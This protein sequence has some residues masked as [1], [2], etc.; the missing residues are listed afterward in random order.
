MDKKV[1]VDLYQRLM[2]VVN[3]S[4]FSIDEQLEYFAQLI[5][6]SLDLKEIDGIVKALQLSE[7]VDI[8]RL[9]SRQKSIYFYYIA[10][11]WG[12]KRILKH[13]KSIDG[14]RWEWKQ[15]ELENELFYLRAS[16]NQD[17]FQNLHSVTKCHILTN[18]GNLFD[19]VG[20]FIEA[21]EYWDR[22]LELEPEFGLALG[23][24]GLGLERYA[25]SLYDTGHQGL[26]LKESHKYLTS[27]IRQLT[28]NVAYQN[29]ISIFEHS[30]TRTEKFIGGDADHTCLTKE[31]TL[32]KTN[33]EKQY[34]RWCLDNRLFL[35]PLND[36]GSYSIAAQDI[37]T[38]PNMVTGI[39][40]G[41]RYQGFYN[42]LKQEFVSARY[43]YY[44]GV[45]HALHHFSD[46]KVLLYNTLDYPTYGISIERVR[47]SFRIA[48][49]LLDKIAYFLNEYFVLGIKQKQ[50][51]F[52][53]I[54]FEDKQ[55]MEF[56][57]LIMNKKNLVLRGL[58]WLSK[59]IFDD[60]PGFR[61]DVEPDAQ[62]LFEIRNNLEHK[63]LKIHDLLLPISEGG[64]DEFLRD[65]LAYSIDRKDFE[66][67][68]LRLLRMGRNALIYLSLA[69][70]VEE[71]ERNRKRHPK[72]IIVPMIS[73]LWKDDWKR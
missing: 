48:Y 9:S 68:T 71:R 60:E 69:I 50:I 41:P 23:N 65:D 62:Q 18:I 8:D 16:I 45:A 67:K 59:D 27:A 66:K 58:Y 46:K 26:F 24:K 7:M 14:Y 21:L 39:D 36:L 32:G 51:Y 6:L 64:V 40:I 20:R 37:L 10:N 22:A 35:N 55:R 12:N 29:A 72:E 5:D 33:I 4:G 63:Y 17:G 42:Q 56:H 30:L 19:T 44:E 53:T 57:P 1:Q 61:N 34:R 52:R 38:T 2:S 43:F 47:I 11:A 54:W 3:L 73:D 15:E 70:N 49:S 31:F 13:P 28:E 25:S